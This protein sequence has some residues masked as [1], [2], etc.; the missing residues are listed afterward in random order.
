[1]IRRFLENSRVLAALVVLALVILTWTTGN[2]LAQSG[3]P[4]ILMNVTNKTATQTGTAVV[5]GTRRAQRFVARITGTE[6]SGTASVTGRVD[7]SP[8][9]T[10]W[11]TLLTFTA[12]SA[13]GG[14]D[15]HV[16][17][18]NTAVY[19]CLRG[20]ATWSGS[21]QW[22]VKIVLFAD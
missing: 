2:V 17:Q 14:E 16:N 18:L 15:V 7:H 19:P 20:V 5:M 1:M 21:G 11:S 9:C 13:S 8:D 22:D 12:L 6:D 4:T 3:Q 10:T